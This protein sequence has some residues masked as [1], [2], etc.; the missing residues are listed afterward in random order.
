MDARRSV[1]GRK[2]TAL[3]NLGWL[4]VACAYASPKNFLPLSLLPSRSS[5]K[6]GAPAPT[7]AKAMAGKLPHPSTLALPEKFRRFPD[8]GTGGSFSRACQRNLLITIPCLLHYSIL[9]AK[10][11]STR[12]RALLAKPMQHF[13]HHRTWRSCHPCFSAGSPT[14]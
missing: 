7:S 6:A 9:T 1:P 8:S 3:H 5:A 11:F 4:R 2:K 13:L 14:E 10:L 12:Q